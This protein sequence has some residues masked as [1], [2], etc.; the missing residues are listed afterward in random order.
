M[1][2]ALRASLMFSCL[3]VAC[4]GSEPRPSSLQSIEPSEFFPLRTGNA[5]S[6]DVDTGEPSTTLGVTRV[7]AFDGR[8]A[9]VRTG[10]ATVRYEVLPEGIRVPPGD[11]WLLRAP[12]QEGASWPARGGRTARLVS[13]DT[14]IETR[15][16]KFER[17]IEV[18][19]TGGKL[20]LEIRIV[21]CPG[22]GPVALD[23]TMRSETSERVVTVFARLRGF[24]VSRE[25]R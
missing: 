1:S 8:L 5:W 19:E 21:Y 12:L 10:R 15:A 25:P 3:L 14:R 2:S 4:A 18:L 20:E 13:T 23:S 17:C 22:V 11:V 16:G 9:E 7:E 24:E 6:Y